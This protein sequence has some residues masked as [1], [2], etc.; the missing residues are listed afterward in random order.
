MAVFVC[1]DRTSVGDSSCAGK[2]ARCL[3]DVQLL[4]AARKIIDN[5]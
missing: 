1:G 4:Q 2:G 3:A 5:P